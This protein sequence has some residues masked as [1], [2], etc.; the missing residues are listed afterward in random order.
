ML[1]SA[2]L[3][4]HFRDFLHAG[5]VGAEHV[6]DRAEDAH[7]ALLGRGQHVATMSRSPWSGARVCFSTVSR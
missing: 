1:A 5:H 4:V 3:Q 6:F 2:A 7:A